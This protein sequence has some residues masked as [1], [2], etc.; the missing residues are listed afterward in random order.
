MKQSSGKH[1]SLAD[2]YPPSEPCSCQICTSYCNRP[3]WWTVE[4]AEKAIAAGYANRMML[5]IAPERDFSVLSP[6]FKG[7]ECNFAFQHFSKNGCTFLKNGL[8]ELF[9]TGVEPLE[10]RFCH[11]DRTGLGVK[12]HHDIENEWKSNAAK[13]LIVRWGNLTGFWKQQGLEVNE[14]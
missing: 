2:K 6:A 13:R 7:N 10:C 9:G 11:H 12:C 5:E 8:C 1:S 4:E 14:K 3:G